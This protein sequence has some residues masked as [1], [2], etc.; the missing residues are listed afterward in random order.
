MELDTGSA[1]SI[2][3]F[4]DYKEFPPKLKRTAVRL[5][6]YTGERI[7]PLG[8]LKYENQC[9]NMYYSVEVCALTCIR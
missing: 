5:K 8:K 1:L 3:F 6:T 9:A 2:I 7:T 4:K